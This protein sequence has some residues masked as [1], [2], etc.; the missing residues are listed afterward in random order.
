MW[1]GS[2]DRANKLAG[3]WLWAVME[4]GV[5]VKGGAPAHAGVGSTPAAAAVGHGKHFAN[6]LHH[7]QIWSNRY[8]YQ[9]LQN[10]NVK[11][12]LFEQGVCQRWLLIFTEHLDGRTLP[13]AET[14]H[15]G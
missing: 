9:M 10:R 13:C 12:I 11:T 8:L 2:E 6:R 5:V 3:A 7:L 14:E 1:T 4:T 15:G